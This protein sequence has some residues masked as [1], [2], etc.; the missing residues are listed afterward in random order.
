MKRID[1]DD[2]ETK[3]DIRLPMRATVQRNAELADEA[4]ARRPTMPFACEHFEAVL[5]AENLVGAIKGAR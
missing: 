2:V 3:V 5:A 4:R 1:W